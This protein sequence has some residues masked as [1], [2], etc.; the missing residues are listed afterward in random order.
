MGYVCHEREVFGPD[1]GE[2]E[3]RTRWVLCAVTKGIDF[4][5]NSLVLPA[6]TPRILS[7][8]FEPAEVVESRWSNMTGLKAKEVRDKEA[9]KGFMMQVFDGS[10]SQIKTLTKGIA[11][12]RST[13]PKIK[14][15]TNPD[16]LRIPTA[17][18]HARCKGV[19]E[20]L[21]EGLSQTTAHELLGQGIVY[22]PFRHIAKHIGEALKDWAK[23]TP[24]VCANSSLFKAAA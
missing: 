17:K 20:S 11:K 2:L 23:A 7:D 12:N 6:L 3:G 10:E 22:A 13:D 15:P 1:F 14:H 8:I 18:E 9:G 16:L 19:P 5:I 21:I 4:D 24:V